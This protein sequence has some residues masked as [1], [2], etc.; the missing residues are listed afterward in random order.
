[1]KIVMVRVNKTIEWD[2]SVPVQDEH[3]PSE[4]REY[5]DS[6]NWDKEIQVSP[7]NFKHLAEY[8]EWIVTGKQA[9]RHPTQ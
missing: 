1:M 8:I 3:D 5:V 2:V 6:I 9:Q 7:Q 4:I